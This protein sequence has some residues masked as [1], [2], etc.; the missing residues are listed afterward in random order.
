VGFEVNI[1]GGGYPTWDGYYKGGLFAK[2]DANGLYSIEEINGTIGT[3]DTALVAN[4]C[5]VS[6]PFSNEDVLAYP[7]NS[8]SYAIPA[9]FIQSVVEV[10]VPSFVVGICSLFKHK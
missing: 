10:S 6:S 7:I 5:Y 2:R 4:R 8:A 1:T 3:N 9:W